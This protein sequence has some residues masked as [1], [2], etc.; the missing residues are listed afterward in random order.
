[1][2]TSLQPQPA[3]VYSPLGPS[4]LGGWLVLVQIGLIATILKA[5]LNLVN[6]SIPSF[7]QEYWGMLASPEG[8]LY[9][10]LWAPA[11][12]F[13]AAANGVLILL[14][15]FTLILFYQQKALMPRMII[16]FFSFNLLIGIVAYI[17]YLNLPIPDEIEDGTAL[18]SL[19]RGVLTCAI[20]IPYFRKSVRVRN[21]FVR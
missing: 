8:Q 5:V 2:E 20:W 13:E 21:T 17:F 1:M 7:S 4:G 11:F 12:I 6:S 3:K 14:A 15:V 16:L 19:I 18:R 10:P 9:H